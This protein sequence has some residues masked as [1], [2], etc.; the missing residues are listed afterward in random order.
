MGTV[1]DIKLRLVTHPTYSEYTMRIMKYV[2]SV[3]FIGYSFYP[4]LSYFVEKIQN[5]LEF[6]SLIAF[7]AI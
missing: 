1:L 2:Y 7:C 3:G 6:L 5:I 4:L